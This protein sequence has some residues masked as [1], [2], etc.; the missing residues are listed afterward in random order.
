M[1]FDACIEPE[2]FCDIGNLVRREHY[3]QAEKHVVFPGQ[4][5]EVQERHLKESG[6]AQSD[7]LSAP[8]DEAVRISFRN[9]EHIQRSH[10]NLREQHA[11]ALDVGEEYLDDAVTKSD[12]EQQIQK[13]ACC[14]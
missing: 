14:S 9:A 5:S 12:D 13:A 3:A 2:L 1:H 6:Y 4:Q 8:G 10:G 7:D 11:A